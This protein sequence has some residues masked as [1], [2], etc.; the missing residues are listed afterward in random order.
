MLRHPRPAANPD[1]FDE[2]RWLWLRGV[3][4]VVEA[5][6]GGLEWQGSAQGLRRIIRGLFDLKHQALERAQKQWDPLTASCVAALVAGDRHRLPRPIVEL[7]ERTGTVHLLSVSG[8]HVTLI[9][10]LL[11]IVARIVRLPRRGAAV[12][13][14]LGLTLYCLLTGAEPPIVRA[15]L[16]GLLVLIGLCFQRPADPLNTLAGAAFVILAWSP[17]TLWD[18]GFQLSF[19]SVAALLT[20]APWG[21][22]KTRGIIAASPRW[23]RGVVASVLQGLV[24]STAVW[25][26]IWPLVAHHW[27]RVTPIAWLANLAAVP[28][29]ALVMVTG[30]VVLLGV[31]WH[32]WLV[33]P[34]GH[35]AALATQG[36][37]GVLRGCARLPG[38]TAS[39]VTLPA[40]VL[41]GWYAALLGWMT[42]G[43]SSTH[44]LND[45]E[46]IS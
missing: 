37:V 2:A 15:T 22:Q 11:W 38:A 35:A 5:A 20:L 6:D 13:T 23:G 1:A 42:L 46:K 26:G 28:L 30:L 7:F 31:G 14:M 39:D 34:W 44:F 8:W 27:H 24:V 18:I 10:G 17:R 45:P 21:L 25:C 12:V 16:T 3:E 36:L 41:L 32:P 19:L 29:A 33:L 40:W 43:V 4:G 9:G